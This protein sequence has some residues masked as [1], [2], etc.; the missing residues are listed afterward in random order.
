MI[1]YFSAKL[2]SYSSNYAKKNLLCHRSFSR[3]SEKVSS[4]AVVTNII[5]EEKYEHLKTNRT[6]PKEHMQSLLQLCSYSHLCLYLLQINEKQILMSKNGHTHTQKHSCSKHYKIAVV[7]V[8]IFR[9][10]TLK[11]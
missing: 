7:R 11:G 1:N 8:T 3:N 9:Q 2:L 10:C 4:T 5:G 6:I